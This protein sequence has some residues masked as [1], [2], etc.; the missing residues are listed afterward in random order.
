[1]K[2]IIAVASIVLLTACGGNGG[3]TG[4][5]EPI[6]TPPPPPVYPEEGT[7]LS[8]ECD[9]YTVVREFADGE[10]GSYFEREE[11]WEACGYVPL[12][13]SVVKRQ[14]DYWK[15]VIIEV[16]GTDEWDFEVE[17]GHARRTDVGLEITSDGQLGIFSVVIAGEQYEYELVEAPKCLNTS[18]TGQKYKVDC[19]GYLVGPV[20]AAMIYY[21]EE[22]TQIVEIEIGVVR[23]VLHC[24]VGD[25][26]V[27]SEIP[28][29]QPDSMSGGQRGIRENVEDWIESMNAFNVRNKVYIRFKL[30]GL[31]W[32]SNWLDIVDFM[33]T[34]EILETSDVVIGYGPAIGAGGKA[35]M[36]RSIYER[37]STPIAVT[38]TIGGN[39]RNQGTATHEIGHAMG[40]GHGVWGI[41]DWEL[42]T[43][44]YLGQN[45]GSI[46]PRFGHGWMG[47]RGESICGP[48]G[49]VMSYSDGYAWSNSLNT[50][51]ELGAP[52]FVR[53]NLWNG[54]AG[55]RTQTDEAYALNRVRYSYSLIH[56]EHKSPQ[57]AQVMKSQRKQV[58][59]GILIT[60]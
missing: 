30:S 46:F 9:G 16:T 3:D 33:P 50:C 22:D 8:T 31:I 35:Y 40:L 37:M 19:E 59:L 55:S 26:A 54:Y 49:S 6:V 11:N 7:R 42:D 48:H 20:S 52:D 57:T 47:K 24:T 1:M 34:R 36:P 23:P 41:P 21:G 43:G 58:D 60:D 45:G 44:A 51:E 38:V 56:N 39:E 25:C 4:S 10:G 12:S 29:E 5:N 17:A 2:G 18:V 28:A 53:D 27:G 13:V 15:P 32:G 14:G